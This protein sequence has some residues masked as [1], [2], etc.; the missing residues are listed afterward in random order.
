MCVFWRPSVHKKKKNWT[1]NNR[2][3]FFLFIALTLLIWNFVC[4]WLFELFEMSL[5]KKLAA[6]LSKFLE[7]LVEK[8]QQFGT[9]FTENQSKKTNLNSFFFLCFKIPHK[10]IHCRTLFTYKR[11]H[12][13]GTTFTKH[14][15]MHIPYTVTHRTI[16][17]FIY[18]IAF[19]GA[20]VFFLFP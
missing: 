15:H 10:N 11:T 2:N 14:T 5:A 18:R 6:C 4:V 19:D 13:E 7:F 3:A 12:T 20:K 16:S 9:K 8:V 17:C 1:K